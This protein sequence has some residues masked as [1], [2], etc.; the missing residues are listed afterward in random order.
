M[1]QVVEFSPSQTANFLFVFNLIMVL[2]FAFNAWFVPKLVGQGYASLNYVKWL[3]AIGLVL[4]FFAI[5]SSDQHVWW[6]WIL[7]ALSATGLILGQSS[8]GAVFPKQNAGLATTS[9]NLVIFIGAFAF[10]WGIGWG[11]DWAMSHGASRVDAFKQVFFV[12]VLLQTI[13]YLW[14]IYYPQPL[15]KYLD[16]Q[17]SNKS[18]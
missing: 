14:F 4:Q 7:V 13:A 16:A 2:G 17:L 18:V 11:I 9:Y 5:A 15:K 6:L 10:Q 3:L 8:V 1:T 12:F